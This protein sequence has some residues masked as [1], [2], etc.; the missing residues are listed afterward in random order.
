MARKKKWPDQ[1]CPA[2]KHPL[3]ALVRLLPVLLLVVPLLEELPEVLVLAELL[4]VVVLSEDLL[5]LLSV[6]LQWEGV[7]WTGLLQWKRLLQW[8]RLPPVVHS[9]PCGGWPCWPGC[10][11]RC[12]QRGC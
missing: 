1:G 7:L 8:M 2:E 6:G 12:L 10:C 3:L 4:E 11:G 9:W 5:V